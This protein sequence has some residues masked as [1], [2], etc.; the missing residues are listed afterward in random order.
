MLAPLLISLSLLAADPTLDRASL[1][2]RFQ[3][4]L[5]QL[6]DKCDELK[7]TRE[8][9]ATRDWFLTRR[10]IY[11][12][13]VMVPESDPLKP[14]GQPTQ[15]VSF[16][17]EKLTSLRRDYAEQLFALAKQ[18]LAA[19]RADVAYRLIHDVL[20]ENPDHAEARRILGYR[21]VSGVWRRP[22]V[23]TRVKQLRL[24]HPKFPWPAKTY[25]LIESPHFEISTNHSEKAGLELAEK[26]EQLYSAWEQTFFDYWSNQRQLQSYFDGAS[27]TPS[28]KKFRIAYFRSQQEYVDYLT[29]L[30]PQAA[31]TLGIYLF[32]KEE[33]YFFASDDAAAQSTWL[34][35]ATHQ[36]FHEY[37][38]AP[39]DIGT[40]ANFWAIEGAALYMESVRMFDGYCTIGGFDASR[41]QFARNRRL[42]G[43]FHL[44]V[45]ELTGMSREQLQ[46]HTD[47]RALYSEAAGLAHYLMDGDAAAHRSKF[48]E[49]LRTIYLGRDHARSLEETT[50]LAPNQ[51]DDNYAKFLEVDDAMLGELDPLGPTADLALGRTAVTDSGL[52]AI[53]KL[54]NLDWLD[55]TGTRVTS[56]GVMHLQTPKLRDLGLGG[57]ATTDA[58][59]PTIAKLSNL[60][61]LD[62]SGTAI[63]DAGLKSLA[64]LDRLQILR[65]AV[66]RVTDAGLA[67][68]ARCAQLSALD[69]RRTQTTPGGVAKIKQA[70]PDLQVTTGDQ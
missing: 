65:L 3:T 58:A 64:S 49:Y 4:E 9:A 53:G 57:T 22:G 24:D 37:R 42:V 62:L 25:W 20:R 18:E 28:R 45:Q 27:P 32:N 8:A 68:L 69:L 66:T 41:L 51:I 47:I 36:L 33:A 59:M 52:E 14:T 44:P 60:A 31:M 30:E 70:H 21:Q 6:A 50:G 15:L 34:H 16:W 56:S 46:K 13:A 29:P 63:T 2:A 12:Y 43:E 40:E 67:E 54:P 17:Y 7:M 19:D 39:E 5:T 48:I 35:E 10:P 1:D 23:T 55:L 61:E 26:L 38:S 11:N